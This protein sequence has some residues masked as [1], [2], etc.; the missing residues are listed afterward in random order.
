MACWANWAYVAHSDDNRFYMAASDHLAKGCDINIYEYDPR[1]DSFR[2]IVDL[3]ELL[4]WTDDMY[5]DG[6][7]HGSMGIMPDGTL[8]G[9]THH[10]VHPTDEWYESGYRGCWLFSYN[11]ETGEGKNWGTP[12]IGNALPCFAVDTRRGYLVGT[13]AA[14]TMLCWD[15]NEKRVRFAGYP[16]NGWVWWARSMLLDESTGLFWGMDASEKPYRFLSFDPELNRFARYEVT[17]PAN[18]VSGATSPL[19][20]HTRRPA[21][22]GW[23]YWATMNGTLLKFK[24]NAADGPRAEPCGTTWA[25]GCDTLQLALSPKGRYVYYTPK[26]SSG[27]VVQYDVNTGA[28]K[29]LGF[30]QE[31]TFEKYGYWMGDQVYG[32][33]VSRDGSF[34]V[35]VMNGTFAGRGKS[36]GHPAIC[37]VEIPAS[38]RRE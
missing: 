31:Y 36:F 4:G 15:C 9:A 34:L 19:R 28:K 7:L 26:R 23:Y 12:L 25:N 35:I 17:V 5:T 11:T 3:D 20:G 24:P 16:P 38:E 30:L 14:K 37:V 27:A 22:D 6:K 2:R 21:M 1:G 18:P 29:V 33:D 10:G 8:W 13:G 32:L